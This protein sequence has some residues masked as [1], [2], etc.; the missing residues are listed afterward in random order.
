MLY[1]GGG[2]QQKSS[3]PGITRIVTNK[4][5]SLSQSDSGKNYTLYSKAV[6][7]NFS[8]S[9][10]RYHGMTPKIKGDHV[11]NYQLYI[12]LTLCMHFNLNRGSNLSSKPSSVGGFVRH[13]AA[14]GLPHRVQHGLAVPRKNWHQVN[15]LA[16]HLQIFWDLVWLALWSQTNIFSSE[17]KLHY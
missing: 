16:I 2:K 13:N 7:S 10:Y 15:H 14:A 4:C 8:Q 11:I 6:K 5:H 3:R 9:L 1:M 17:V 12:S